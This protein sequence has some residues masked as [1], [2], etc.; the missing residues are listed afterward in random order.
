[1]GLTQLCPESDKI[2]FKNNIKSKSKILKPFFFL[3][4]TSGVFPDLS[5]VGQYYR[6]MFLSCSDYDL[7]Y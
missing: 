4:Y 6:V 2:Q 5:F 1:M 3:T 7:Y